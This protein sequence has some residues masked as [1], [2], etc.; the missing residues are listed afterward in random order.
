M[1]LSLI[2][3][4]KIKQMFSFRHL[5]IPLVSRPENIRITKLKD[6][7]QNFIYL[8]IR[9]IDYLSLKRF[10]AMYRCKT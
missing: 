1:H 2:L 7:I 8:F 4:V 6:Q 5:V 9:C 10:W 3:D